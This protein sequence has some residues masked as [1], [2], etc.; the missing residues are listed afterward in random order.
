MILRKTLLC[1]NVWAKSCSSAKKQT[2][3]QTWNIIA[4]Y[5]DHQHDIIR[6]RDL[7]YDELS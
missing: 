3:K 2:T 4:G 1:D 5:L 6:L 7:I